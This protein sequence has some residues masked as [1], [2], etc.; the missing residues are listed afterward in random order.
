LQ[1]LHEWVSLEVMTSTW[2]PVVPFSGGAYTSY[3]KVSS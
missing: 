3:S 2:L 1:V